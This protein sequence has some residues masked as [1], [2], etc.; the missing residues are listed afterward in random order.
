MRRSAFLSLALVVALPAWGAAQVITLPSEPG[1]GFKDTP[2]TV[3]ASRLIP[4]A[5]ADGARLSDFRATVDLSRAFVVGAD[6]SGVPAL[7]N[8]GIAQQLTTFPQSTSWGGHL[9]DTKEVTGPIAR[10]SFAERA[11]T[12]GKGVFSFGFGQQSVHYDRIDG[13]DLEN[14]D[15]TFVFQHNNC[16]GPNANP[17]AT[18]DLTPDFERDLL[19]QKVGIDIDRNVFATVLEFGVSDRVDLGVVVPFVKL[20]MRTR[21]FSRILRTATPPT[22]AEEHSNAI[23]IHAFDPLGLSDRTTYASAH[24]R[25]IGDIVVRGKAQLVKTEEGGVSV[26][27]NVTVPTGDEEN[28]LGTGVVRVEARGIWSQQF[29][30]VGAHLNGGYTTSGGSLP[31]SLTAPV[32][33][34]SNRGLA[35]DDQLKLPD[36]IGIVGGVEVA[37]APRVGISGDI[38]ARQLRNT[39]QFAGAGA[40]F[41]SRFPSPSTASFA[42]ASDLQAVG[43]ANI[44]Q[45][46]AGLGMRVHIG[47]PL[48]LSLDVLLPVSGDGLLPK[49]AVVGGFAL[50]F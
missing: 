10:S 3:P 21:V 33:P 23:P 8:I 35:G 47:R 29:G 42:A 5:I 28:L 22:E 34:L 48:L 39:W 20:D 50:A 30:R 31:A 16:C 4:Q 7:L 45:I 12:L 41:P 24:A 15:L 19:E 17:G 44:T 40:T 14:G 6:L 32:D 25:G 36:E 46:L 27:V 38:I 37:V 2:P 1:F 11:A 43:Q 26:A 9:D 18:T 49:A 13:I